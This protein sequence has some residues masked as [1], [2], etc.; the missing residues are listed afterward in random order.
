MSQVCHHAP[1]PAAALEEAIRLL[2]LP[3]TLAL[4][5]LAQHNEEELRETRMD[6]SGSASIRS[7]S[8]FFLQNLPCRITDAGSDS[9]RTFRAKNSPAI[10]FIVRKNA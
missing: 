1:A 3:G 8:E 10:C 6:T 2:K 4:L 7:A 5:D 9:E